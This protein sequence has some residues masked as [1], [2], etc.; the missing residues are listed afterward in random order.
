[1][2]LLKKKRITEKWK[3]T[4]KINQGESNSGRKFE[5]QT[6]TKHLKK[7][8]PNTHTPTH[9]VLQNKTKKKRDKN[10]IKIF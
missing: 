6:K 1:M 8:R 5:N 9:A 2:Y 3:G 4:K 7:K 10:T